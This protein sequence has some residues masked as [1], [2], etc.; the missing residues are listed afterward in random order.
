MSDRDTSVKSLEEI[1]Q[2]AG[3]GLLIAPY[4]DFMM[5]LWMRRAST[6][7]LCKSIELMWPG[8]NI[9][10]IELSASEILPDAWKRMLSDGTI[11]TEIQ[12]TYNLD[13]VGTLTVQDPSDP[14]PYFVSLDMEAQSR[15]RKDL[16]TRQDYYTFAAAGLNCKRG[17]KYTDLNGKLR[18]LSLVFCAQNIQYFADPK[19]SDDPERFIHH[20]G[21]SHYR[22]YLHTSTNFYVS[23]FVE[24]K[25][26]LGLPEK[27]RIVFGSPVLGAL[28]ESIGGAHKMNEAEIKS[29]AERGGEPVLEHLRVVA[30]VSASPSRAELKRFITSREAMHAADMKEAKAEGRE[31][32]RTEG[33]NQAKR[34]FAQKLIL[35]G[36]DHDEITNLTGLSVSEI[37]ELS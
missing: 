5:K 23:I 33:Q 4:H 29:V 30:D 19:N 26:L 34:E 24:L 27:D 36:F 10:D 6:E 25:K 8:H 20:M 11:V 1:M 37:K 35:R 14:E 22:E 2:M 16:V 21:G 28:L 15:D 7:N 17:D 13:T 12:K 3:K 9:M 31:E 32:G 18:A